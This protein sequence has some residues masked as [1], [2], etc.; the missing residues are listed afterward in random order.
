MVD[1]KREKVVRE[2]IRRLPERVEQYMQQDPDYARRVTYAR[3]VSKPILEDLTKAGY[4]V[5]TLGELRHLEKPWKAALPILQRW[6]PL[7][8]ELGV[9]EDIVRGLSVPWV[10]TSATA[11]LIEEFKKA[12]PTSSLAWAIGNALSIVGVEG[13]EKEI[14]QLT[15]NRQY[16]VARQ[17]VVL[18][19]GRLRSW[20]H[21]KR[22]LNS[23]MT[24]TSSCMPSLP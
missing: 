11:Q 5:Q 21:R 6:L 13:F 3:E 24:R 15:L 7:V 10:G 12:D 14:I 16:G 9:K 19:L 2:V 1:K 20:E 4:K 18:G 22:L 8:D 17:M 23:S